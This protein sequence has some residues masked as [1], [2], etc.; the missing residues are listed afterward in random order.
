MT[1][2]QLLIHLT[3][4]QVADLFKVARSLP[5][6]KL[7]W[8]PAPGARSA[9]DQLQEVATALDFFLEGMKQREVKWDEET[10]KRWEAE[11][12]KLTTLDELEAATTRTTKLLTDYLSSLTDDELDEKV[13]VPFPIEMNL[14]ENMAYHYWNMSYHQG[15]IYYIKSMLTEPE[16]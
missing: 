2:C 7:N 9:L 4:N 14:G 12:A 5:E 8:K 3:N 10:G 15:Q 1:A 6:D 11:R 13:I 16:G